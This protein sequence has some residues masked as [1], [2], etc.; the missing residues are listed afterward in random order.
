MALMRT[1][2]RWLALALV[3]SLLPAGVVTAQAA[4]ADPPPAPAATAIAS[5]AVAEADAVV[6]GSPQASPIPSPEASAAPLGAAS[7]AGPLPACRYGDRE[8]RYPKVK[9]W[10]KTLL[11][12]YLRV[13]RSYAPWDLVP[14]SRAGLAGTGQV[15]KVIIEDLREL[16]DAARRAG[17]SLA[18]RSAY[19]SYDTQVAVFQSWVR[20]SGYEEALKFSARPGHSEHQ[21]GT[22]IDF[23]TGPGQPLSSRFGDTPSG[24]WLARNGWRY[25]FVMSYPEGKRK[26]SCYGFEPWHWRYVGR[27][28]AERIYDSGQVPRRYLWQ[29]SEG[30]P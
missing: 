25:G 11:D 21:L 6:A 12:T 26:V 27:A 5:P 23:T 16:A 22:T 9:H 2:S 1:T 8:T 24:K 15:R 3:L 7:G 20:R 4:S 19:R 10:R 29:N 30:L 14:V 18:V 13:P 17:K 28:T